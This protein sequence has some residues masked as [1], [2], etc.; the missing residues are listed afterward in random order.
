[1]R[2]FKI[3]TVDGPYEVEGDRYSM[4]KYLTVYKDDEEVFN[5]RTTKVLSVK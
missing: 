1:M 4:T 3:E 2:V 5:I